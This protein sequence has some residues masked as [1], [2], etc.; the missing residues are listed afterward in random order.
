MA[1]SGD[2][3][4]AAKVEELRQLL[5]VE[6]DAPVAVV[7]KAVDNLIG[8]GAQGHRTKRRVDRQAVKFLADFLDKGEEGVLGVP[9]ANVVFNRLMDYT[10]LEDKN[11]PARSKAYILLELLK[12]QGGWAQKALDREVARGHDVME[13]GPRVNIGIGTPRDSMHEEEPDEPQEE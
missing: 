8:R 2:E 6:A 7:E 1:D 10:K 11:V 5:G 13:A 4:E 3:V 9:M 12:L